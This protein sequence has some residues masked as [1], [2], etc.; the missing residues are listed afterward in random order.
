MPAATP[1]R[2]IPP[3]FP[4]RRTHHRRP[5]MVQCRSHARKCDSRSHDRRRSAHPSSRGTRVDAEK[6]G[7]STACGTVLRVTDGAAGAMMVPIAPMPCHSIHAAPPKPS[8][9]MCTRVIPRS[10]PIVFSCGYD[11]PVPDFFDHNLVD[12]GRVVRRGETMHGTSRPRG[13]GVP[14]S[15]RAGLSRA[16]DASRSS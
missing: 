2:V 6:Q 9:P 4:A 1:A 11:G 14:Q 15:T 3:A 16:P 7:T 13:G 10:R 5:P 12:R 8:W